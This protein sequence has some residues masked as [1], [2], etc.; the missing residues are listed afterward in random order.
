[1]PRIHELEIYANQLAKGPL[2]A[3]VDVAP[4]A[5]GQETLI[6]GS[7]AWKPQSPR[8][9]WSPPFGRRRSRRII[10]CEP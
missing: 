8:S 3:I 5:V 1:M 9:C 4:V 7:G 2:N 6:A 10:R